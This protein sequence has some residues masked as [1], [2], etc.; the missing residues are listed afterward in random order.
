MDIFET[1]RQPAVSSVLVA[2]YLDGPS[3]VKI[4]HVLLHKFGI[5]HFTFPVVVP[6]HPLS[7]NS[8]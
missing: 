5:A 2:A 8:I 1:H 4:N 7:R 6:P 3:S